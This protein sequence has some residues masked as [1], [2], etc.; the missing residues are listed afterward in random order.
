[1]DIQI[2]IGSVVLKAILHDTPTG[3]A[4]YKSLPL[5]DNVITWG[6]EAYFSIPVHQALDETATE[7]VSLGDIGYWP[8]GQCFCVFWGQQPISAVSLCGKITSDISV[9]NTIQN[10]EKITISAI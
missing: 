4:I 6:K 7:T 10:N 9:L 5:S 8:S 1:M 3:R 2:Q